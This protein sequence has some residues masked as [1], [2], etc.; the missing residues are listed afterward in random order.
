MPDIKIIGYDEHQSA[1]NASGWQ[2]YFKLSESPSEAWIGMFNNHVAKTRKQIRSY[3]A[4][5]IVEDE[6]LLL[7]KAPSDVDA[8]Q[9][10]SA[11]VSL[12]DKVNR[13]HSPDD[14]ATQLESLKFD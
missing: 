3:S 4:A 12:V 9:I 13:A 10:K 6:N 2:I 1:R 14:A 5:E 7:V 8:E 11:M